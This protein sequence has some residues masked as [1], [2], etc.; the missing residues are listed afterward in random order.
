M[1]IRYFSCVLVFLLFWPGLFGDVPDAN[2]FIFRITQ[3]E[4]LPHRFEKQRLRINIHRA[5]AKPVSDETLRKR[6]YI[7]VSPHSVHFPGLGIYTTTLKQRLLLLAQ[8]KHKHITLMAWPFIR[9]SLTSLSSAPETI[10]DK[11]GWKEAQFTPRV[12][13]SKTCFTTTSEPKPRTT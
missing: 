9:Q 1:I 13:P 3:H 5:K 8:S 11:V 12:C 4:L 7:D 10:R 6:R 2:R